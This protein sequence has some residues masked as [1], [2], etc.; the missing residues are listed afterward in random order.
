ME[1]IAPGPRPRSTAG[2][3]NIH[4]HTTNRMTRDAQSP[5][6]SSDAYGQET[7]ED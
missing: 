2:R 3:L 6:G 4:H 7:W 1:E 5:R